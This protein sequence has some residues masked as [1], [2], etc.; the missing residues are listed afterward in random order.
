MRVYQPMSQ[1][2][3]KYGKNI[4]ELAINDTKSRVQFSDEYYNKIAAR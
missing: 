1:G 3:L 2:F 4:M